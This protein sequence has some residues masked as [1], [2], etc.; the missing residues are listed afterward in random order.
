MRIQLDEK[1][2]GSTAAPPWS[3]QPASSNSSATI[4][5]AI[6]VTL[7]SLRG[8]NRIDTRPWWETHHFNPLRPQWAWARWARGL[9]CR[10][11]RNRLRCRSLK[12][13]VFLGRGSA[14]SR[15]RH[16]IPTLSYV[17]L[18]RSLRRFAT[19]MSISRTR[20]S[21]CAPRSRGCW[22]RLIRTRGTSTATLCAPWSR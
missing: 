8:A 21:W 22:P 19:T 12:R 13:G 18:A 4:G 6:P 10:R 20:R 7:Q 5:G 14:S 16:G 2:Q 3:P 17:C 1:R 11:R 9:R 15:Q